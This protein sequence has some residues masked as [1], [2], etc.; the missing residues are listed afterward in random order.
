[1]LILATVIGVVTA[2]VAYAAIP[3]H[4]WPLLGAFLVADVALILLAARRNRS[5]NRGR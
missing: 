1:M 3:A 5:R 2:A 4:N